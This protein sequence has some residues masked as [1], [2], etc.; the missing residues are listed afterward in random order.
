MLDHKKN[1]ELKQQYPDLVN[2][3]ER[4]IEVMLDMSAIAFRDRDLRA[5]D[6]FTEAT[7]IINQTPLIVNNG[8]KDSV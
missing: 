6:V 2:Y 7:R 4:I 3:K 1:A 5:R 8:T